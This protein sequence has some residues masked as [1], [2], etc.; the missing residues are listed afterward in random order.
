MELIT[1]MRAAGDSKCPASNAF[2]VER[3]YTTFA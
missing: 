2:N 1:H 3:M